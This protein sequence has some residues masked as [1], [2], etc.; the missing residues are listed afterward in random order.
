MKKLSVGLA[1]LA[2]VALLAGPARAQ[3]PHITPFSF[4]ARAGVA[5]PQ[6]DFNNEA[7]PG[8]TVSGSVTYH[9]IPVIGI[10]GGY[11]YAQ[12]DAEGS[13]GEFKDSGFDAGLRVGI[14]TPLI[15]IDPYVKA[16]VVWN[17][18]ELT[19]EGASN[20]SSSSAGFQLNAGVALSL[21]PV[22]LTPGF[23]Y[24]SYGYDSA[25]SD[26]ETASYI[27]ADVGVRIRI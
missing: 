12:F 6:G 20:F 1:T 24:V 10:Y 15:P 27:R 9:A 17:R 5:L 2:G 26:D 18:L 21:G 19:G 22:S 13:S 3:I 7:N 4:E 25:T 16:G 23:T 14:P 8:F 11:S